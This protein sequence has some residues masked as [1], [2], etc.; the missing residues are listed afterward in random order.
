MAGNFLQAASDG[1][2][3]ALLKQAVD[4]A[5]SNATRGQLPFGAVVARGDDVLAIG[6][7]TALRGHDPPGTPRSPPCARP[8]RR[9]A[10]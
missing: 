1:R 8:A 6:V 3:I 2:D 5:V 7:N 9:S 10:L 4:L